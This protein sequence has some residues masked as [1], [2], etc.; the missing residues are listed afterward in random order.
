MVFIG[1]EL[2]QSPEGANPDMPE[3]IFGKGTDLLVGN[4]IADG[5]TGLDL[6]LVFFRS[7]GEDG[8]A[9]NKQGCLKE[10]NNRFFHYLPDLP[11]LCFSKTKF[12]I[13]FSAFLGV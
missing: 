12:T 9:V 4:I 2:V 5:M 13:L 3:V 8:E 10:Y 11:V 7:T 1:I 6:Q